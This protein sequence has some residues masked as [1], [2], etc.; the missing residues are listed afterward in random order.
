MRPRF[1]G[2][3]TR[4]KTRKLIIFAHVE[5]TPYPIKVNPAAGPPTATMLRLTQITTH[6]V[7]PAL[8]KK[9]TWKNQECSTFRVRLIPGNK[10]LPVPGGQLVHKGRSVTVSW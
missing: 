2:T 5:V 9:N 6:P 8:T 10:Q 7:K 3:K 1:I 4:N